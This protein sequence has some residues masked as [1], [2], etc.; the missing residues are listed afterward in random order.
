MWF[1]LHTTTLV[2]QAE[3]NHIQAMWL[4]SKIIT[5]MVVMKTIIIILIMIILTGGNN[6]S[7]NRIMADCSSTANNNYKNDR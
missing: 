3:F 4:I 5:E 7:N 2:L 1:Y 6:N